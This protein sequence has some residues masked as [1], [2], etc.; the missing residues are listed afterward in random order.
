MFSPYLTNTQ[1]RKNYFG[2]PLLLKIELLLHHRFGFRE[3]IGLPSYFFNSSEKM[4]FFYLIL[5][6]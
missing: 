2:S 5:M 3:A 1:S 6:N 4:I